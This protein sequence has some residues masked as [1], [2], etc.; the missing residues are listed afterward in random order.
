MLKASAAASITVP[1]AALRALLDEVA[2]RPASRSPLLSSTAGGRGRLTVTADDPSLASQ[3]YPLE[4]APG[5]GG[6]VVALRAGDDE[7]AYCGLLSL[8]RLIVAEGP[9]GGSAR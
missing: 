9:P 8:A 6:P 4:I 3:A 2:A 7:G 5:G 1:S